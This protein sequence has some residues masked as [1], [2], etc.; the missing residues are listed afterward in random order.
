MNAF[1]K[2]LMGPRDA[3]AWKEAYR[4]NVHRTAMGAL[5]I[6]LAELSD[7]ACAMEV[8]VTDKVRQPFGLLHG[9]V[10]LLLAESV[11]S[12]HAAWLG[13]LDE[14]APVGIDLNGTHLKSAT[15]G[16]VRATARVIRQTRTFVFHEVDVVHIE[17]GNLLC[18]ARVTNYFRPHR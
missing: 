8:D 5:G 6:E 13:D 2:A 7:E 4:E 1:T 11:T 9:G 17:T 10:S 12:M 15:E 3:E 14:A 16:R 18:R